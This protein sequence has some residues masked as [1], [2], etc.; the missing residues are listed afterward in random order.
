M[1]AYLVIVLPPAQPAPF[2]QSPIDGWG[3]I[4]PLFFK[5][6]DKQVAP[7]PF[8]S[9]Y[10]DPKLGQIV[11]FK[12]IVR[13]GCSVHRNP[14]LTGPVLPAFLNTEEGNRLARSIICFFS[15]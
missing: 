2:S 11:W 14:A 4:L 7:S 13:S 1:A 3:K 12:A 9:G 15:L 6:F 8:C 5:D 10:T